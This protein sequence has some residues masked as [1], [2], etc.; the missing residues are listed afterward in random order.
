MNCP[1]KIP[2]IL[3][4]CDVCMFSKDGA[5]DHP[6]YRGMSEKEIKEKTEHLKALGG[7]G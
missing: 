7:K 5:C 4:I 6:Y 2:K 1:I 3:R